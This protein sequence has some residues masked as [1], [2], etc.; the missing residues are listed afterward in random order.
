MIY[1]ILQLDNQL[2]DAYFPTVF[3]PSPIP[4]FIVKKSG[5][6]PFI[7]AMV[8]RKTVPERNIDTVKSVTLYCKISYSE[9][10][11][12]STVLWN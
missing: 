2:N 11:L 9:Y 5:P 6:K 8:I 10:P 3:Y 4:S 12:G 1:I 7:E